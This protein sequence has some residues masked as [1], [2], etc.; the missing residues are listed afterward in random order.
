MNEKKRILELIEKLMGNQTLAHF[1]KTYDFSLNLFGL[2]ISDSRHHFVRISCPQKESVL[3][4]QE[5]YIPKR[6][7]RGDWIAY[8]AIENPRVERIAPA[9]DYIPVDLTYE[10]FV[11]NLTNFLQE[12][13]NYGTAQLRNGDPAYFHADLERV[14]QSIRLVV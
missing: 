2:K 6:D 11:G 8:P 7:F 9:V 5:E 3:W 13:Q 4:M 12:L 14:E 10:E 1:L